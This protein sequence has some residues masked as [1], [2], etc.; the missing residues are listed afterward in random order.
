MATW[1]RLVGRDAELDR[2]GAAV[3]RARGGTPTCVVIEGDAGIGKT[4]LLNEAL[5]TFREQKDCVAIGH[6]V[7]LAG[8][9]LPYGTITETLRT[10]TRDTGAEVVQAAAGTYAAQLAALY[11]LLSD[12]PA[13]QPGTSVDRMQLLPRT[14][15]PWRTS[16]ATG[17]SGSPSRTSTGSTPPASTPSPT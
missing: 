5:T 8:G 3:A 9:E 4:R 15:P 1:A 2:L 16:P 6:G 11:P 7:E 17:S 13:A 10:L 12:T 14:S